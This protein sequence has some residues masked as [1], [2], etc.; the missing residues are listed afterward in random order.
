MLGRPTAAEPYPPDR[1]ETP[2]PRSFSRLGTTEDEKVPLS[3]TTQISYGSGKLLYAKELKRERSI[4]GLDPRH[5][6]YSPDL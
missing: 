2:T 1:S 5:V 4:K 6:Q 3:Q